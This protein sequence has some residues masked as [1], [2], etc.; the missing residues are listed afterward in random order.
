MLLNFGR[1][2]SLSHDGAGN[3][4][5]CVPV[6]LGTVQGAIWMRI[7][8][9]RV[10]KGGQKGGKQGK[11]RKSAE[12]PVPE[13]RG[14]AVGWGLQQAAAA[15]EPRSSRAAPGPTMWGGTEEKV[16]PA[17]AVEVLPLRGLNAFTG[18]RERE[19]RQKLMR[20]AI[21]YLRSSRDRCA[22]RTRL[23]LA[24]ART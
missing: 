13:P 20:D 23:T 15:E 9:A 4:N 5:G 24:P 8:T 19:K 21:S 2:H 6:P 10:K 17:Y 11:G 12:T 22:V 3:I 14:P 7:S 16:L 18:E 1:L